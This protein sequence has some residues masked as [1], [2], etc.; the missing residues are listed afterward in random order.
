MLPT[1]CSRLCRDWG[2]HHSPKTVKSYRKLYLLLDEGCLT[3][4][5]DAEK[6]F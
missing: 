2:Y 5:A 3:F 4:C 1:F 6:V